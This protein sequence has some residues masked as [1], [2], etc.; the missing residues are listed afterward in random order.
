MAKPNKAKA[1]HSF[2]WNDALGC[3][4]PNTAKVGK[5]LKEILHTISSIVG[6]NSIF[7]YVLS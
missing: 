7:T 2:L 1:H 5:G 4:V 3:N 6:K